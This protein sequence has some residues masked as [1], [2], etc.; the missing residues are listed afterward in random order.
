ME[1]SNTE[2]FV[3]FEE[4]LEPVAIAL[5]AVEHETSQTC[6]GRMDHNAREEE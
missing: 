5:I 2:P 4:S 3:G 1:G 6:H